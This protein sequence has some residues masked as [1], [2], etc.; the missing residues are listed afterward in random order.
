MVAKVFC[1]SI[2]INLLK[3]GIEFL[4]N[5]KLMFSKT[6]IAKAF[7]R[8]K[9][10]IFHYCILN[11]SLIVSIVPLASFLILRDLFDVCLSKDGK[12]AGVPK[13]YKTVMA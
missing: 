2:K 12:H 3:R 7:V 5:L 8:Y 9:I 10:S 4:T 6:Y 11:F 13:L 1:F